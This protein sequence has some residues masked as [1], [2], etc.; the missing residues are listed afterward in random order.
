MPYCSR[1]VLPI[2]MARRHSWTRNFKTPQLALLDLLDNC[3]DAAFATDADGHNG[4]IWIH[5]DEYEFPIK[6]SIHHETE[7]RT[8]GMIIINSSNKKINPLEKILEVYSSSKGSESDNIGENGV[9]LKQ[10]CATI[11]DLSI[12]LTK[13]KRK[14]S[15]GIIA[16]SLQK[17]EG[18][19]LPS[20]EFESENLTALELEMIDVFAEGDGDD[21]VKNCIKSYGWGEFKNGVQRIK[22][23]FREMLES[24][25]WEKDDHV[26]CLIMDKVR[27]GTAG[28]KKSGRSLVDEDD[29]V[30]SDSIDFTG[31]IPASEYKAR[32]NN[33]M[34]DLRN[35][36][37]RQYLHIPDNFDVRVGASKVDFKYWQKRLVELSEIF[38]H[39]G[40][41]KQW[42]ED[43][44][45]LRKASKT[46]L[47]G[48]VKIRVFLG[49]DP[50]RKGNR[51]E[52][53]MLI[54]SRQ[55]GQ[56]DIFIQVYILKYLKLLPIHNL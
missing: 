6:T 9:G 45:D 51:K 12:V 31:G 13:N 44:I 35:S 4:K 41:D 16:A 10:G 42:D 2:E 50:M 55:T 14:M 33:L 17:H 53:S 48:F 36:L 30:S 39:I 1:G 11:S 34:T 3:F 23:R 29:S 46:L 47:D 20:W 37:P 8:T 18:C 27:H 32:V 40:T 22:A 5:G 21:G 26:F 49:F 25:T 54:Y 28:S 15:L 19:Y 7:K 56:Y 52:A 24:P 38:I 43:D